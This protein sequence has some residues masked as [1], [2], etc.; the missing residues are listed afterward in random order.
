MVTSKNGIVKPLEVNQPEELVFMDGE[1]LEQAELEP[2]EFIVEG[3][4]PVGL[5][6]LVSPPKYGKSWFSLDFCITV[7]SGGRFLGFN[8]NQCGVLYLAL[9]DSFQRLQDRQRKVLNGRSAPANFR[10]SIK[11]RGLND[12]LLEQ[13]KGFLVKYPDTKVVVVDTFARIRGE[14][15]K[16][17]GAYAADYREAG[18]VKSF[19]DENKIA[20]VLVHHTRKNRDLGDVFANVSGTMGL[21]GAADTCLVL[22]RDKRTDK[23][24][25]LS[26]TGRDVEQ[27]DFQIEFGK[28]FRWRLLGTSE[29]IEERQ[30]AERFN[31][32]LITKTVTRLLEQGNGEWEGTA[33][34]LFQAGEYIVGRNISTSSTTLGKELGKMSSDFNELGYIEYRTVK[35]K[36][37]NKIHRFKKA[38]PFP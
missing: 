29:E 36:N 32:S 25:K 27:N 16:G 20:V 23:E 11:S 15:K 30:R 1:A 31:E 14:S 2:V 22:S 4:I 28:D 34:E 21:L 18:K 38:C 33:N 5:T 10:A 26:V 6:F 19:A 7:A 3:L 17:E 37:G 13:L 8:C 12:G 24:T 35:G 9:E